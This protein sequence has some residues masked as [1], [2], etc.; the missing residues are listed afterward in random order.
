MSYSIKVQDASHR[1]QWESQLTE[2]EYN[3]LKTIGRAPFESTISPQT[4]A[5]FRTQP[6]LC[7]DLRKDLFFPRYT[8]L[9]QKTHK[10][11]NALFAILSIAID[12]VTLPIRLIR[13][14][15]KI[16]PDTKTPEHP[17][18]TF[19]T[20]KGVADK[21]FASGSLEVGLTENLSEPY[22]KTDGKIVPGIKT[23][24]LSTTI[25]LREIPK[26]QP[27][28]NVVSAHWANS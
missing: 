12:I 11:A 8:H 25:P 4:E 26:S 27:T 28:W 22:K 14:I 3:S 19:M 18:Q 24:T 17:L 10:V 5:P 23:E 21:F 16:L 2:D 7:L 6:P 20:T 9:A 13:F 1:H 15:T